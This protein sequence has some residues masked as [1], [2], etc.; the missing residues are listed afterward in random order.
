MTLSL[1]HAWNFNLLHLTKHILSPNSYSWIH[2]TT[3][4]NDLMQ[5]RYNSVAME[6]CPFCISVLTVIQFL[7]K[8]PFLHHSKH[9][10]SKAAV[11]PYFCHPGVLCGHSVHKPGHMEPTT[12]KILNNTTHIPR[13]KQGMPVYRWLDVKQH[14]WYL[15]Y[16]PGLINSLFL[17][18]KKNVI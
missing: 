18:F 2:Y 15:Q 11:G 3:Y 17:W 16:S 14:I 6:L 10:S 12:H 5:K 9:P 1:T 7:W 4:F 8:S 13:M